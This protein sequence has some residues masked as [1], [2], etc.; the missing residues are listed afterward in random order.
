MYRI[1]YRWLMEMV[2]RI[3]SWEKWNVFEYFAQSTTRSGFKDE[4]LGPERLTST[5]L[6]LSALSTSS[7]VRLDRLEWRMHF[8]ASW[9]V[10]PRKR[11]QRQEMATVNDTLLHVRNTLRPY[12]F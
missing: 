6:S 3:S 5:F 8:M 2:F 9:N 7:V 12:D 4:V 1:R 10:A 11:H